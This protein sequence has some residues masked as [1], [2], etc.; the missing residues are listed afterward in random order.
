ML[1]IGVSAIVLA[2]GFRRTA[3]RG[4][5]CAITDV[6]AV[7]KGIAS[8]LLSVACLAGFWYPEALVGY[9]AEFETVEIEASSEMVRSSVGSRRRIASRPAL[10][11]G[12]HAIEFREPDAGSGL[13]FAR[14]VTARDW[15]R[16]L[17]HRQGRLL[18]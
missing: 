14:K 12:V 11:T 2:S 6:P 5:P 4:L 13:G 1:R 15:G 7:R 3:T 10:R 16:S 9:A 17:L 18:I 8:L